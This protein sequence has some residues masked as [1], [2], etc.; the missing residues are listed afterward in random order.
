MN[1]LE[2]INRA[3]AWPCPWVDNLCRPIRCGRFVRNFSLNGST[4]G[5]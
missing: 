2:S 5:T 1:R 4:S 3:M